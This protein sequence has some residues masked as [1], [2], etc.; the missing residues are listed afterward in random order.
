MSVTFFLKDRRTRQYR[1][2]FDISLGVGGMPQRRK[3]YAG[4]S[5]L[6]NRGAGVDIKYYQYPQR[7]RV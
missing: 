6:V 5:Y 7:G 1:E 4:F 3:R 2:V